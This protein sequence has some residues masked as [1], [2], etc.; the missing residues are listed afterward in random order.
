VEDD[1]QL[2]TDH[3]VAVILCAG[4][5]TRMR[6][7]RNK[8]FMPL[9]GRPLLV[10]TVEAFA[11]SPAIDEILLVAHPAEVEHVRAAVVAAYGLP[12]VSGVIAGGA[13]R[14]QSEEQA[15]E[16]LRPRIL[17]GA[18][19]I[20]LIHDGARPLVTPEEI[21]AVTAAARAQGGAMLGTPVAGSEALARLAADATVLALLPAA[22]L[23][24]AQTP[25]AFAA[26]ELLAAYDAAHETGFE[27]TDTAAT[28][29][30]LGH[31]VA[32]VPGSPDNLKVTTPDDLICAEVLL[33][34]RA[35]ADPGTSGR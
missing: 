21:A 12:R 6:A 16:A 7:D 27:G 33:R 11:Q 17:S 22:D 14:H 23:W 9:A 28:Y 13:T 29:E 10:T 30:R 19:G 35:R 26:R 5:G 34:Q 25:Q 8:V 15:L 2:A 18:V 31:A 3:V 4:Q 20:V 1:A 32:M 24:H